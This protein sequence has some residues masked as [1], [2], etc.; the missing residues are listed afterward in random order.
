MM[1]VVNFIQRHDNNIGRWHSLDATIQNNYKKDI[2]TAVP[3][4]VNSF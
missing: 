3:R 4:I 1:Y 2:K